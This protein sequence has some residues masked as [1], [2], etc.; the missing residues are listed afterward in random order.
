MTVKN[1][2]LAGHNGEGKTALAEA[3][4]FKVGAIDRLGA[5][6]SGTTVMDFDP[7]ETKRVFSINTAI[8]TFDLK[9]ENETQRINLIDTPGMFDFAGGMYE[10]VTA[11][12][13]V[14][15]PV[16]AKSGV[17]VGTKKAFKLATDLGKS[18]LIVV[19]KID[20]PN[21]NFYN[22]LTDLKTEFGAS[23]CPVIVPV[24]K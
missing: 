9:T 23:I 21:A 3:I 7:E 13:T 4:L 1:I 10:G 2:A 5:A 15:I 12:N 22:T 19:T 6:T 24:I 11:A 14:I 20:D 8:A 18:K 16:S 17:K